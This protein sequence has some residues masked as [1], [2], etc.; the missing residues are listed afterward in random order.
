VDL[1]GEGEA[2]VLGEVAL[3]DLGIDEEGSA[4]IS[5][6]VF[7]KQRGAFHNVSSA[8]AF[9]VT[10]KLFLGAALN[11][12]MGDWTA[13]GSRRTTLVRV[14]PEAGR[15]LPA[16]PFSRIVTNFEQAQSMR[17]FNFNTG[18]LLKY[19][20]V[21]FG[22]VLRLPFSGEYR[23]DETND[24]TYGSAGPSPPEY[25]EFGVTSRLAWPRSGGLGVAV[26]PFS[27]MTLSADVSTALW[28]RAAIEDLPSG[29]LLTD[30]STDAAG[31]PTGFTDRNFFD[32]LPKT[33][34]KTA[35]TTQWR[36]GAEYLFA[37][38]RIVIP[39]RAGVFRSNSP[40]SADGGATVE[41]RGFTVGT[42]INF[43]RFVLDLAFERRESEAALGLRRL[44]S[45]SEDTSSYPVETVVFDRI[46]AS[47]ILRFD[48]ERGVGG[49]IHSLFAGKEEK[50]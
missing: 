21:S 13:S 27:G 29:A 43:N 20:R 1:Y 46:V 14:N 40:F 18:F 49:F 4:A 44:R 38:P 19:E 25:S 11:Y 42:G 6:G 48:T 30:T 34:T 15:P 16:L 41:I 24:T 36:A 50:K 45:R 2:V 17:G 37:F 32:L 9:Q 22:G 7:P 23:L 39:V 35:D 10:D 8:L 33:V 3:T 31:N 26:R 12:W 5:V 28:S 47:L